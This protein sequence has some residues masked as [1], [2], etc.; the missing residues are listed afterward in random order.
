MSTDARTEM[1]AEKAV[2]FLRRDGYVDLRRVNNARTKDIIILAHFNGKPDL[3]ILVEVMDA[4]RVRSIPLNGLGN[5]AQAKKKFAR[6]KEQ[7]KE[8]A[9]RKVRLDALWI[10]YGC[11]QSRTA[12]SH[13]KGLVHY[14]L[15]TAWEG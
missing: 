10:D 14:D 6:L 9:L 12:I 13:I 8:M 7:V 5:N 1:L 15:S 4:A 2:S 3:S 11:T